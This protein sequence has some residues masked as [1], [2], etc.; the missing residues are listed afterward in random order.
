MT[1]ITAQIAQQPNTDRYTWIR[2]QIDKLNC[3]FMLLNGT[4]KNRE[5]THDRVS[6]FMCDL[7]AGVAR[8]RAI[9]LVK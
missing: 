7:D 3:A 6:R 1:F 2:G 5:K 4:L 9:L 8:K